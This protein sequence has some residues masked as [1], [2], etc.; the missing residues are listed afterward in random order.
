MMLDAL[1]DGSTR[2]D[3]VDASVPGVVRA[4][5]GQSLESFE[6]RVHVQRP[7]LVL[8]C[9]LSLMRIHLDV[10]VFHLQDEMRSTN[11]FVV[12]RRWVQ[13]Q[14]KS[15]YRWHKFA[16][17]SAKKRRE[18]N[19]SQECKWRNDVHLNSLVLWLV[20][21]IDSASSRPSSPRSP[22]CWRN[23][24]RSR[25]RLRVPVKIVNIFFSFSYFQINPGHSMMEW[26]K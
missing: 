2:F 15:A 18:N 10:D 23:R 9:C 24:C 19:L 6:H 7:H 4:K 16:R 3:K 11:C 12:Y 26:K 8:K 22:D 14:Y 25:S 20:A 21:R 13:F 17:D 1:A 5:L